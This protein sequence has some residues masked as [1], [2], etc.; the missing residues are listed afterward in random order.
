MRTRFLLFHTK[1]NVGRDM[2]SEEEDAALEG[3]A[4]GP[5]D[6]AAASDAAAPAPEEDAAQSTAAAPAPKA[7]PPAAAVD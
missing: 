3:A 7:A 4:A 5:E 6:T 1:T 2:V